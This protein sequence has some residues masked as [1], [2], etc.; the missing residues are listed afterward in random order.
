MLLQDKYKDIS[1]VTEWFQAKKQELESAGSTNQATTSTS[2]LGVSQAKKTAALLGLPV[3][4]H[5]WRPPRIDQE[6]FQVD[7]VPQ[8]VNEER[9]HQNGLM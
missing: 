8:N 3:S 7:R 4:S 5:I 2:A 9:R 6:R 1:G